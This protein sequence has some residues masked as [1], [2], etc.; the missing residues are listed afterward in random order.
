MDKL[1]DSMMRTTLWSILLVLAGCVNPQL[2][3]TVLTVDDVHGNLNTD[4]ECSTVEA[5]GFELGDG[6][7]A[8]CAAGM[9]IEG[10]FVVTYS[11]VANGEWVGLINDDDNLQVAISFGDASAATNCS[12]GDAIVVERQL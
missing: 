6:F 3:G 7:A 1:E 11:D 8:T 9:R 10:K 12:A 2:S 5:F 4:I